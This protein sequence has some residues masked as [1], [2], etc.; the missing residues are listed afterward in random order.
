MAAI[1]E[2]L[3]QRLSGKM[4]LALSRRVGNLCTLSYDISKQ[5]DKYVYVNYLFTR[6]D[7]KI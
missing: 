5:T 6:I 7:E 4:P 3:K 2:S 1:F